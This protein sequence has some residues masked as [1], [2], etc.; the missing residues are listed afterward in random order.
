[1][2]SFWVVKV[3]DVIVDGMPGLRE[4]GEGTVLDEFGF[5]RAPERFHDGII[6][7]VAPAAHAGDDFMSGQE[8]LEGAAG[9][10]KSP[11]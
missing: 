5:E 2:E 10:L 8:R 1:M 9:I 6:V 4:V 11:I 3:V 7:A